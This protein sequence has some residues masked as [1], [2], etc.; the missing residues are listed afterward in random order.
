MSM[1]FISLF[2]GERRDLYLRFH[3]LKI[4]IL[5]RGENFVYS[6]FVFQILGAEGMR[7]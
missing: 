3:L 5:G 1:H 7:V 6:I 2:Y 4:T